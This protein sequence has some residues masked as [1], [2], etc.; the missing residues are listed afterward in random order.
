MRLPPMKAGGS[1][2][3]PRGRL[4][5]WDPAIPFRGPPHRSPGLVISET[6]AAG[7]GAG[8]GWILAAQRPVTMGGP[9]AVTAGSL[10]RS[11]P[12]PAAGGY[13]PGRERD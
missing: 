3:S 4:L 10:L 5:P 2:P 7:S 12:V 13:P 8:I 6:R 11:G 1:C 9:E